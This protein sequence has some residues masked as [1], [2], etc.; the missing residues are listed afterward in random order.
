MTDH[1]TYL[2]LLRSVLESPDDDAPRLVMADWLEDRQ[3]TVRCPDDC[4]QL[5][6]AKYDQQYYLYSYAGPSSGWELC[7]TCHG[8]GEVSNGNAE[9][10]EFIRVQCELA[11]IGPEHAKYE[12]DHYAS[13]V[14]GNGKGSFWAS[15]IRPSVGERINLN[16]TDPDERIRTGGQIVAVT[17]RQ[18]HGVLVTHVWRDGMVRFI[19]DEKSVAWPGGA[20]RSR[21]R[22]LLKE[23]GNDW[24]KVCGLTWTWDCGPGS[25]E[26]NWA[27]VFHRGFISHITC[28]GDQLAAVVDHVCPDLLVECKR[29]K[30]HK[31]VADR[32]MGPYDRDCIDCP[33]CHGQGT[34]PRVL[35][36]AEQPVE[37]VRLTSGMLGEP[38]GGNWQLSA[39]ID[40]CT[41]ILNRRYPRRTWTLILPDG[42][43]IPPAAKERVTT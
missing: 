28:P 27:A 40:E 4:Q 34:V 17:R 36:G 43:E 29:C 41:Q 18:W 32:F 9:R 5:R 3:G 31:V 11:R 39:D 21:E 26:H 38:L 1:P 14:F 42:T 37:V 12:L 6:N 25:S 24:V 33:T 7:T 19:V 2:S 30:G 23:Y 13:F 35:T 10:A 8:T 22:E 16:L 20:L 15:S